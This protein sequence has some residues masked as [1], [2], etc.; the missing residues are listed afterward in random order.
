MN[1]REAE[2]LALTLIAANEVAL[3][4]DCFPTC[5][6]TFKN[7]LIGLSKVLVHLFGDKIGAFK[8]I[9]LH[10]EATIKNL[11]IHG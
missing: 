8:T 9:G 3:V 4:D 6:P 11:P 7:N 5:A 10:L 1:A 2:E